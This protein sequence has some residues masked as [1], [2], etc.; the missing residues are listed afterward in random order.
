MKSGVQKY[1]WPYKVIYLPRC[2][3]YETASNFMYNELIVLS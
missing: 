2:A 3:F 1:K